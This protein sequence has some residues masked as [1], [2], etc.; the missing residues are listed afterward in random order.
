[1][2]LK[3]KWVYSYAKGLKGPLVSVDCYT[4]ENNLYFALD[5]GLSAFKSVLLKLNLDTQE[6]KELFAENHTIRTTGLHEDGKLYLTSMKGMAYCV[7]LNGNKV[8]ETDIGKNNASFKLAMDEERLYVSN[9]TMYCLDKKSGTILWANDEFNKKMNSTIAVDDRYIYSG[10][11][12]GHIFCL[13]KYTGETVWTYGETDEWISYVQKPDENRLFVG[14]CRGRFYI[15]NARTGELL[16]KCNANGKLYTAPVL[17]NGRI[18]V[19]DQDHVMDATAGNMTCYV[20]TVQ[21]TLKEIFKVSVGG[22]ISSKAVIDG[23]RLFFASDDGYLHCV[24]AETG[25]ELMTRKKTKGTC[26]SIITRGNEIIAL[27]DKG[28]AECFEII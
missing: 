21:N 5:L 17:H 1:M 15:F 7:D 28:P 4:E 12:A 9:Y 16:E 8:W 10:E 24:N 27:S 11:L 23:E 22:G 13:D 19:G 6:C 25:E 14:D 3:S 26:R 2:K 18:Y 20:L